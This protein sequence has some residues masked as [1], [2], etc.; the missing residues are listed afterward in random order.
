MTDATLLAASTDSPAADTT[1]T[2]APAEAVVTQATEGEAPASTEPP[3]EGEQP[4]AEGEAEAKE[5]DEQEQ[6]E[7]APEAYADFEVPEGVALDTEATA[8]FLNVAKELNLPQAAAQKV[9]DLGVQMA[10]K[11]ADA[12]AAQVSEIQAG[13]RTEAEADAEIGGEALPQNLAVA[14]KALDAF[15]T[16][17]LRTLLEDTKLGDHPEVIRLLVKA[18]KAI[19][20]DG[21]VTASGAAPAAPKSLAE[22]VYSNS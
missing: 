22:R 8:E 13:W 7:G 14:K 15:A 18:G 3:A 6:T 10:Q 2:E 11:W 19:S 5:G 16:P 20:E 1:A 4:A 9:V 12:Q 17:A 21:I